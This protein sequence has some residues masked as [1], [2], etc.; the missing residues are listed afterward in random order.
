MTLPPNGIEVEDEVQ[1]DD[2]NSDSKL[3][4]DDLGEGDP[5]DD[6]S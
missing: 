3:E 2:T 4:D 6:D 1:V 5:E